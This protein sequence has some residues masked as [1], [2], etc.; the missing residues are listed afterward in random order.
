MQ[1]HNTESDIGVH[2]IDIPFPK[3][4]EG[5]TN[6]QRLA[7]DRSVTVFACPRCGHVYFYKGSECHPCLLALGDQDQYH[8]PVAVCILLPFAAEPLGLRLRV[9]TARYE[10]ETN[11]M[12]KGRIRNAVFCVTIPCGHQPFCPK[13]ARLELMEGSN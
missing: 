2:Q 13:D 11:E 1:C 3:Q 9:R 7:R 8:D 12:V 4:L 5:D 10:G 6:P